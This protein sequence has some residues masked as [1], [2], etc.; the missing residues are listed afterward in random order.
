[1]RNI[2]SVAWLLEQKRANDFNK[3]S[4]PMC[5]HAKYDKNKLANVLNAFAHFFYKESKHSMVISD[6][7]SKAVLLQDISFTKI[8]PSLS[9]SQ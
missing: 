2:W 9:S 8:L 4:V 7:Q 3:W 6:F 1:M 5:I